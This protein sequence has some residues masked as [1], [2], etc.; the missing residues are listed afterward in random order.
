MKLKISQELE[1][2]NL[3]ESF[4]NICL[5]LTKRKKILIKL[6]LMKQNKL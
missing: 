1:I 4:E 2:Q 5:V 6:I 3:K